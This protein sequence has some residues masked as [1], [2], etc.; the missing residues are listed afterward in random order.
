MGEVAQQNSRAKRATV[1]VVGALMAT[2]WIGF[3]VLEIHYGASRPRLPDEA[4]GRIFPLNNHG[5]VVYLTRSE[6]LWLWCLE[7]GAFALFVV[8][9]SLVAAWRISGPLDGLS[10]KER[11]RILRGAP[12]DYDKIRAT[13]RNDHDESGGA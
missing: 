3:V 1:R 6:Q 12:I 13:Y 10:P 5:C 2:L 9:A 11:E 8:G 7:G 4:S